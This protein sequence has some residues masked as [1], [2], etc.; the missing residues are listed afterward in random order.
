MTGR[1]VSV[2]LAAML[3]AIALA[4][5]AGQSTIYNSMTSTAYR[6][7][8]YGQGYGFDLSTRDLNTIVL[9]NPFDLD[10][11]Q[12][13]E[14]LLAKF[15]ARAT[16]PQ[17]TRFTTTPGPSARPEF[18]FVLL[19]NRAVVLPNAVCRAP[20]QVPVAELG[21]TTRLTATFC[22][23]ASYLTTVTGELENLTDIDDP[24]LDRLIGQMAPLL[25]PRSNR[26]ARTM[27]TGTS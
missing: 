14:R 12:M 17:P 23:Y 8:I 20:E 5:C 11:Q 27:G 16:L 6:S 1:L 22:H 4:G 26:P 21:S 15:N 9:G 10:Q 24:S 25:F 3:G 19:F 13:A 7:Y 2:A 18:K